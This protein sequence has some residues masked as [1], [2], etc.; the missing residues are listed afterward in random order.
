MRKV[1]FI[2]AIMAASLLATAFPVAAGPGDAPEE[3]G[4]VTRFKRPHQ[5]GKAWGVSALWAQERGG[6]S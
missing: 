5:D 6:R 3:S 4:A 2:T 1:W